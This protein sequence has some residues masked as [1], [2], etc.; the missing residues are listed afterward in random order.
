MKRCAVILAA[1]LSVATLSGCYRTELPLITRDN[2]HPTSILADGTYCEAVFRSSEGALAPVLTDTCITLA[3]APEARGW[4]TDTALGTDEHGVSVRLRKLGTGSDAIGLSSFFLVQAGPTPRQTATGATVIPL[5]S[6]YLMGGLVRDDMFVL[7]APQP[8]Q[9]HTQA[10]ARAKQYGLGLAAGDEGL[11]LRSIAGLSSANIVGAWM[12]Q[13]LAREIHAAVLPGTASNQ[14]ALRIFVPRAAAGTANGSPEL[15]ARMRLMLDAALFEAGVFNQALGLGLAPAKIDLAVLDASGA[16]APSVPRPAPPAQ[17]P[18]LSPP[19]AAPPAAAPSS[20]IQARYDGLQFCKG[21]L[22]ALKMHTLTL[23]TNVGYS[24]TAAT[25]AG[26]SDLSTRLKKVHEGA[27]RIYAL[28]ADTVTDLNRILAFLESKAVDQA[29]GWKALD[30]GAAAVALLP[31]A[32]ELSVR[33]AVEILRK[34]N[35][36]FGQARDCIADAQAR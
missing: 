15:L 33:Q 18:A 7:I 34:I 14:G 5:A 2:A 21:M 28:L 26:Q 22:D 23:Q 30:S 35:E 32:D 12:A 11:S 19:P 8:G 29:Q 10:L 4:R 3:W 17:L 1:L 24:M 6:A 36:G 27:G 25:L 20:K 31:L 16:T 13:E 9:P